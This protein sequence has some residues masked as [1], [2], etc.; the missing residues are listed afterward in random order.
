MTQSG[1]LAGQA[2]LVTGSSSG[3]GRAIAVAMARAGAMVAV[4]YHHDEAG[5]E[6]TLTAIRAAGGEGF[7]WR[8]D[9][10]RETD[11]AAL[12]AA[13]VEAFGT[14]DIVVANAGVQRDAATADMTLEAWQAVID[15]NLTGT[16]LCARAALREFRRPGR[17]QRPSRAAGKIVCI[18]SVHEVVPW[19]GHVNYAASK[20]GVAL[21]MKSIAQEVAHER[22]RVVGIA[23]G[24]IRTP[25]NR[26]AWETPEAE[27]RLQ[28]LIPYG[29]IGEPEDIA[30]A[31][32][33]LA[34]DAADYVT[35]TTL[36]IDGGMALY[37]EFR[38]AG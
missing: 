14:L 35:G 19:S 24:A 4:N 3:I 23:P 2:S 22:I 20:G 6:A 15:V 28:E 30:A 33:W 31:A 18:G 16:F 38:D 11:V 36:L 7:A 9:V 29:R 13:A 37:P 12:F 1:A 17:P 10:A 8:A 27:R 26:A 34:S 25:I 5:A 21:L 32:V